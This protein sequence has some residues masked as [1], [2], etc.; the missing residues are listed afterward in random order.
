MCSRLVQGAPAPQL[1]VLSTA[2]QKQLPSSNVFATT[3]AAKAHFT[4]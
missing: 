2:P 1:W 4:N 3:N